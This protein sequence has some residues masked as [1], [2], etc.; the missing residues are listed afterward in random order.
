MC[1]FLLDVP[2]FGEP[3]IN[4]TAPVGR[5]ATLVCVVDDLGSYKVNAYLYSC[6]KNENSVSIEN[7]IAQGCSNKRTSYDT[8][9]CRDQNN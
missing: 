4:V 2:R 6:I 7:I 5:E 9:F 1:A 8:G 3:I